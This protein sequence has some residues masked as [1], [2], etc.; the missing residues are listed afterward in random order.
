MKEETPLKLKSQF[1]SGTSS[2]KTSASLEEHQNLSDLSLLDIDEEEEFSHT[3]EL[4]ILS[5]I[6]LE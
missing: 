1:K 4:S 6:E 2:K 3:S 5:D